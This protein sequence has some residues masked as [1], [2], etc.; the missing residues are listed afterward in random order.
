MNLFALQSRAKS[1]SYLI[2]LL[3]NF[4]PRGF[5]HFSWYGNGWTRHKLTIFG[6]LTWLLIWRQYPNNE[7]LLFYWL[8]L[9]YSGLQAHK[10]LL[11][12]NSA[13]LPRHKLCTC[14]C[15]LSSCQT[16]CRGVFKPRI[17]VLPNPFFSFHF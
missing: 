3:G 12:V 4:F 9:Q 14:H 10:R 1:T 16:Q 13:L 11:F 5:S 15:H 6:V 7:S 8:G 17:I 2:F